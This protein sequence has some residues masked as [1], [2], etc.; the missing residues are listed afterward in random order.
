MYMYIA[1]STGAQ[2]DSMRAVILEQLNSIQPPSGDCGTNYVLH[3]LVFC[4][5]AV[6]VQKLRHGQYEMDSYSAIPRSVAVVGSTPR[7]ECEEACP[8]SSRSLTGGRT[9]G[10]GPPIW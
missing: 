10:G 3:F 7:S 5:G 8:A 4:L 6:P 9:V 1:C 2:R